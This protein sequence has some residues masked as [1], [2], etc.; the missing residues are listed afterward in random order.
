MSRVLLSSPF[1]YHFCCEHSRRDIGE[2]GLLMPNLHPVLGYKLVWLTTSAAPK[3]EAV[4]LT[5]TTIR[6]DRMAHR[7]EVLDAHQCEP[8]Y[9]WAQRRDVDPNKVSELTAWQ[10]CDPASWWVSEEPVP[11]RVSR[12]SILASGGT[13]ETG[14]DER[15]STVPRGTGEVGDAEAEVGGHPHDSRR[16]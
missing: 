9:E 10:E 16:A 5:M 11:V 8:F 2:Y 12:D 4:G 15:R 13:Q 1:L 3:R 6:C 7:Y 14:T